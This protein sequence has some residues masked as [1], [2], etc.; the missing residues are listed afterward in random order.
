MREQLGDG[1]WIEL[2]EGFVPDH[3]N[4]NFAEIYS[5][6][7]VSELDAEGLRALLHS[8][9]CCTRN[10]A[11]DAQGRP[12]NLFFVADGAD[13]LRAL[14]RAGWSETS[15]TRDETYRDKADYFFGRVPEAIF[16]KGRDRGTERVEL[17]LWLAP[18]RVDGKPLW[19]GQV[20]H[21]IGRRFEIGEFFL[22]VN[23]DPDTCDGRDY[24][25]QDLWYAQSLL[26]WAWSHSGVDT[27][28]D[29]PERDFNGNPW[30]TRD[31]FRSV[32]WISGV[33][34]ALSEARDFKWATPIEY[35]EEIR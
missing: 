25:L 19:A 29:A 3:A 6:D 5:P 18:V 28:A 31:P 7:E 32:I 12:V 35:L 27:P 33:P 34:V 2:V 23:L 16:R 4:V 24:L 21:A 26:A 30:F 17:S 8:V 10:R 11:D 22:G 1:A 15:Y 20:R 13:L 9:P 14:V